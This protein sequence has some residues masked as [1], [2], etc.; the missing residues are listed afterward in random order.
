MLETSVHAD[1]ESKVEPENRYRY[2][3]F[4]S[5]CWMIS[6]ENFMKETSKWLSMLKLRASYG[7]TGNSNVGYRIYDYYEV[8]RNAIIGGA[9]STGVYAS[10]LGNRSLTWETTTE[11]NVGVDLGILNNRFK[12]TA[13]YFKRKITDLLV[14][15][16][17]LSFYNEINKI[18]GNI[19]S[20]QSQGVAI[21]VNTVNIVTKDF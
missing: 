10:D 19:G 13:E 3:P 20:T 7:Q 2:F 21:T 17:P 6:E 14:T 11:F 12:L 5:A 18:A 4:V 15:N 1:A 16:K 9:E 8:G